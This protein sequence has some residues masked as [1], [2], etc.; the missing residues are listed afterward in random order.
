MDGIGIVYC[1]ERLATGPID[2]MFRLS[3]SKRRLLGYR[4]GNKIHV[5]N[6]NKKRLLVARMPK[7]WYGGYDM[8]R[9][10]QNTKSATPKASIPQVDRLAAHFRPDETSRWRARYLRE[11]A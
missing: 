8:K 9:C 5:H 6:S 1:K 7:V 3:D 2:V 11:L 4:T 10:R